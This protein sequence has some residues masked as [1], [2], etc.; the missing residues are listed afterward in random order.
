MLAHVCVHGRERVGTDLLQLNGSAGNQT[1]VTRQH[2]AIMCRMQHVATNV[3][4]QHVA[5]NV[6]LQHVATN[7]ALQHVATNAAL[8]H[9]CI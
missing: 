5:T 6:A 3:A 7:V 4:L 2:A 1:N 8:R 9:V